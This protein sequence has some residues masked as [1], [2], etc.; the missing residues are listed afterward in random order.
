MADTT[1]LRAVVAEQ[2]KTIEEL[3]AALE[4]VHWVNGGDDCNCALGC[5]WCGSY[6]R[7]GDAPDCRWQAALGEEARA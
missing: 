6:K 7:D 2:Q 1:R 5:P 4:A 3:R